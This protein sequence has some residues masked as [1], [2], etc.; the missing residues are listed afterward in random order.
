MTEQRSNDGGKRPARSKN[1]RRRNASGQRR[2][3]SGGQGGQGGRGGQGGHGNKGGQGGHGGRKASAIDAPR[4]VA[5]DVLA[6][7]RSEDT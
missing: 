5:L 1:T 7:V 3:R 2:G 6:A 4:Q